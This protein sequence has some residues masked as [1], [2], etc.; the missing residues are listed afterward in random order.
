MKNLRKQL[1]K[2]LLSTGL[3]GGLYALVT[4]MIERSLEIER[5]LV[6]VVLYFLVSCLF[7]FI[8]P[9]LGKKSEDDE[10]NG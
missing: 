7:Y 8:A 3:F 2:I 10:E 1:P 4:F 6:S 9:K 5:I